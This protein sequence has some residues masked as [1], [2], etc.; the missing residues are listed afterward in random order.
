MCYVLNTLNNLKG[1]DFMTVN[2]RFCVK[3]YNLHLF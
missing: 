2:D 1:A 3:I